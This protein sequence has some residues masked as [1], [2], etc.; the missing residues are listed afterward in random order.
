MQKENYLDI[1]YQERS[2]KHYFDRPYFFDQGIRFR[3][4]RC[5]AC[6]TGAPGAIYVNRNEITHIADYLDIPVSIFLEDYVCLFP[7]G[8]SIKEDIQGNCIFYQPSQG[9]TIYS[10]RPNQCRYYPFWWKNLR[11]EYNWQLATSQCPGIGQGPLYTKEDI[12]DLLQHT[13]I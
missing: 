7:D 13:I 3:C 11:N 2:M 6:C 12:L 9:C 1:P 8:P 10:V 5:G 4:K